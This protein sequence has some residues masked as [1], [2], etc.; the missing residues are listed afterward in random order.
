M[1]EN[2]KEE[3]WRKRA[4]EWTAGLEGQKNNTSSHDV[5]FM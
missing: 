3:I 1:Y 4:E 2:T 5:G